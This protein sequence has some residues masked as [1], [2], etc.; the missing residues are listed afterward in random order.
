MRGK[1]LNWTHPK[2]DIQPRGVFP[3]KAHLHQP[4]DWKLHVEVECTTMTQFFGY[5]GVQL[6][7]GHLK[8]DTIHHE[9]ETYADAGAEKLRFFLQDQ[10]V[11]GERP[12]LPS[13]QARDGQRMLITYGASDAAEIEAQK[14][15]VKNPA[16]DA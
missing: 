2:F 12:D 1:D 7:A 8:L 15:R 11:W 14:A 4:N 16:S 9:G 5:M 13:V 10:G 3:L 6:H